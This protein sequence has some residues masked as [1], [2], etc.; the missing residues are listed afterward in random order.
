MFT[1]IITDLGKIIDIR[2]TDS[3]YYKIEVNEAFVS[4]LK[5]GD[6]ISTDG[7]CLTA[8][9][10]G[11][12][13]FE[14][15]LIPETVSKTAFKNKQIGSIVNLEK[16]LSIGQRLDGHLVQGHIDDVA[17]VSRFLQI[18][19]NWVLSLE[20]PKIYRKFIAYKGS[21]CLNG[22]SLTISKKLENGLEVSLIKHTL[23]NTN[24]GSLK[25]GDIINFEVDVIARY[26]ENMIVK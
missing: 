7:A 22:V 9:D 13:Y 19:D 25:V 23:N 6:S 15:Q 12:N 18:E 10:I 24:L 2:K 4:N 21:I 17:T 26:L 1:G 3:V 11:D 8:I 20:I 5:L 14:L 16:A